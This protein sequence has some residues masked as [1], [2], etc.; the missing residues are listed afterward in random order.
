MWRKEAEIVSYMYLPDTKVECGE[1]W[2]W[3]GSKV[4][5]DEWYNIRMYVKVN[6][7][8]EYNSSPLA[9]SKAQVASI[10]EAAAAVICDQIRNSMLRYCHQSGHF[11]M[12]IKKL[13]SKLPKFFHVLCKLMHRHVQNR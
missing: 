9:I 3:G 8:G 10:L 2:Q 12:P 1:D 13:A 5:S 4:K 7:P 11:A 6:D